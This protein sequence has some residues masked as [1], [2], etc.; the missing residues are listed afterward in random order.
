MSRA[1][2]YSLLGPRFDYLLHLRPAEWP[3]MAGHTLLGALLALGLARAVAGEQMGAVLLG[4]VLWVVALNGGT[5]AINSEAGRPFP[6]TSP[7][8]RPI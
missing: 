1:L 4:V 5:L 2:G 6:D 8:Q 3:I 7:R